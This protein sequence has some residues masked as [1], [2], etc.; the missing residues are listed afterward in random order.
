MA[1]EQ[2]GDWLSAA[3]A[4]DCT[5]ADEGRACV[6]VSGTAPDAW[7]IGAD[8]SMGTAGQGIAA[9]TVGIPVGENLLAGRVAVTKG[10]SKDAILSDTCTSAWADL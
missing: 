4:T 1:L 6:S 9:V 8:G 10:K 5:V 2:T 3:V 7:S